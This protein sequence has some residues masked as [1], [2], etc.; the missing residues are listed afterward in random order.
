MNRSLLPDAAFDVFVTLREEIYLARD[1]TQ[2]SI[3]CENLTCTRPS[4]SQSLNPATLAE[5]SRTITE[6]IYLARDTTQ[7]SILCENLT[8]TRPSLSQS[9]NPQHLLR[10]PNDSCAID[11]VKRYTWLVIPH[12]IPSCVRTLH[13]QDHL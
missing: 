9:L 5:M 6:E 1:T 12:S 2:Y 10:C 3:L 8:C 4:L 11:A 13:A 7:Y